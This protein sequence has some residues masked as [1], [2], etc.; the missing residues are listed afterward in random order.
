MEKDIK[1]SFLLDFYGPLLNENNRKAVELYYNDDLSLSEISDYFGIT[2][3]GVRDIIKRSEKKLISFE[4]KLGLYKKFRE[5]SAIVDGIRET[6][7]LT[8]E[9]NSDK[10]L[11]E[12]LFKI[13]KNIDLYKE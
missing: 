4:E 10:T 3:Q 6:L 2:R 12:L 11:E 7:D 5:N 9:K 1:I 8:I 13:K